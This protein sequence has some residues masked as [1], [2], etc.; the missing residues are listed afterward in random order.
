MG[1][2][3][4][5]PNGQGMKGKKDSK[6]KVQGLYFLTFAIVLYIIAYLFD[7]GNTVKALEASWAIF[8]GII[9][10]LIFVILFMIAAFYLAS[11]K[12]IKKYV[13]KGSGIK[14]WFL[15]VSTGILS[16][17]PIYIWFPMLKDLRA[18]GM[19]N[20]LM[21]TFLYNRAIKLPFLPVMIY[22]FGWVFVSVLMFYMV[23]AS[24]VQGTIFDILEKKV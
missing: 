14:G 1:K 13:G 11:P 19:R 6:N 4:Q 21:A 17:G 12:T 9:P 2:G 20:G 3:Q 23:V 18:H 5:E 24:I 16:H 7:S 15:A 10:T 8:Y 22:Y